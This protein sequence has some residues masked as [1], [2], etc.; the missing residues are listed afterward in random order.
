MYLNKYDLGGSTA[1][2]TGGGRGIG[3]AQFDRVAGLLAESL[4]DAGVPEALVTRI[5][6]AVTPLAADIVSPSLAARRA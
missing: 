3:Q 1:F 2:V 4:R 6:A 5:L